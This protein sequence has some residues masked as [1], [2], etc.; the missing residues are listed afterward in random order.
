MSI[1]HVRSNRARYFR[2]RSASLAAVLRHL[3]NSARLL[4][5]NSALVTLRA[6]DAVAHGRGTIVLGMPSAMLPLPGSTP[7]GGS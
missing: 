1:D 3:A 4:E 7:E 6:L 2:R 5:S